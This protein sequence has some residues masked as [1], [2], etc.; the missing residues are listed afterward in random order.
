MEN[1]I[2]IMELGGPGF[3]PKNL[4]FVQYYVSI[5]ALSSLSRSFPPTLLLLTPSDHFRLLL[6]PTTTTTSSTL[7][8]NMEDDLIYDAL[9]A[10]M[11]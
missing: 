1:Q 10:I 2:V 9:L 5:P 6:L 3:T 7:L 4:M 11:L 8:R